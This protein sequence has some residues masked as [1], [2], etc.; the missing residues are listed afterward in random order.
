MTRRCDNCQK[1]IPLG[2]NHI[3]VRF[4]GMGKVEELFKTSQL[5]FCSLQCL[6]IYWGKQKNTVTSNKGK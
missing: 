3:E 5:D 1:I 6:V 2:V 4:I